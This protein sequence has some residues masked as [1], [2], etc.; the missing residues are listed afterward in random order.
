MTDFARRT[1]LQLAAGA[2]A[3]SFLAP[4]QAVAQA[5]APARKRVLFVVSN[6]AKSAFNGMEIGYWLPEL[7]H[8]YWAFVQKGYEVTIAS[9]DGGAVR[10]DQMS[11]PD[12]G[13]FGNPADLLSVG[14]KHAAAPRAAVDAT[15]PLARAQAEAFD[16]IF[17]VGGFA[18]PTTF[19]ANTRL[20]AL[21]AEFHDSGKVA[22]AICHGTCILLEARGRDGRKIVEGKSWTGYTNAEEDVV[23]RVFGGRFQPF[24]IED[25]ARKIPGTK[26]VQG[27]PYRPHAVADGRLI[28][29]QQGSSGLATAELVV[30]ALERA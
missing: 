20:H 18:P 3:A 14:F 16:A 25:E 19:M 26:F 1:A 15:M 28:T 29:G 21:F 30:A 10:H 7:A 6:P 22:A 4:A 27:A 12:G 24:R 17:V 2:A 8:P 9:P 11:D 23:D 5:Q 13:R